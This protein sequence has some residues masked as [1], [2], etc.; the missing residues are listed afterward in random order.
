NI[1]F[2]GRSLILFGDFGQL[3]PVRDLPMYA[4]DPRLSNNLSE[5]GRKAYSQFREIYKLVAVQRQKRRTFL[6]AINIIPT[7]EEVDRI[8][9]EKL[10]SLNQPIAKIRAVHTGG[11]EAS[12]ADSETAKG[13]ESELLLARNTRVMLTANL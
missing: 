4:K 8:N 6:N 7:W 13:L 3:P 11:P 9:L 12:K 10:R 5:D 1:P 2:G